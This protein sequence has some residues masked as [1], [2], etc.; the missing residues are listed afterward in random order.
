MMCVCECRFGES[1]IYVATFLHTPVQSVTLWFLYFAFAFVEFVQL[2]CSARHEKSARHGRKKVC[3]VKYRIIDCVS[4]GSA[5]RPTLNSHRSR[6]FFMHAATE[7]R[8]H[9]TLVLRKSEN[10]HQD[11]PQHCPFSSLPRSSL[12]PSRK[13]ER[14]RGGREG[15]KS[16]LLIESEVKQ[17]F[18]LSL[19]PLSAADARSWDQEEEEEDIPR[20]LLVLAPL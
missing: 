5:Y 17:V 2:E 4:S 1:D 20:P 10:T 8:K 16:N 19:H 15:R 14:G 6:T 18:L 9:P 13:M 11:S 7:Q 12:F 3:K